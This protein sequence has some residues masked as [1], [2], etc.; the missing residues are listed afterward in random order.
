MKKPAALLALLAVILG[1]AYG[2]STSSHKVTPNVAAAPTH[3]VT[4]G[5]VASRSPSFGKPP[6]AAARV[7]V[8][9]PGSSVLVYDAVTPRNIPST[10][11]YAA[12][13]ASGPYANCGEMHLLLPHATLVTIATTASVEA[14]CLDTEP[15]DAVPSQDASWLRWEIYT[16]HV[17]HPCIYSSLSEMSTVEDYLRVSRIPSSLYYLWDA[18]WTYT[19]H[20]DAGF[21]ATQWFSNNFIDQSAFSTYFFAPPPP[22][23]PS[24]ATIQ[25]WIN[26]KAASEKVFL[27]RPSC[28]HDPATSGCHFFLQR[29]LYFQTKLVHAKVSTQIVPCW[30]K[31]A[32]LGNRFC[33]VVRPTVSYWSH[34]RDSSQRAY[35]RTGYELFR[36][37]VG[38]FQNRINA[39]FRLQ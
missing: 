33:E 32:T 36:S 21:A 9:L 20:I 5:G 3:L 6:T 13:Y 15:Q 19:Y 30:G 11:K 18:D 23:G 2:T 10:A 39:A 35:E 29:T 34:A 8:A 4:P 24:T 7:T 22:V 31:H 16:L 26:A 12:C 27:E 38:Y 14:R 1:I 37:R 28:G 17:Y 25:H